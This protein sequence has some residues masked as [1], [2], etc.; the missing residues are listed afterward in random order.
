MHVRYSSV[1]QYIF[2]IGLALRMYDMHNFMARKLLQLLLEGQVTYT[3][4][5][6][7]T[8]LFNI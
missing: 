1:L 4:N 6:N 3:T 8:Q 5:T 2:I 7:P